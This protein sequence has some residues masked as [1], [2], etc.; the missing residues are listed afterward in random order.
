MFFSRRLDGMYSKQTTEKHGFPSG[1]LDDNMNKIQESN[2]VNEDQESDDKNTYVDEN[3]NLK[4]FIL[5]DE[6]DSES[7]DGSYSEHT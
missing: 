6:E 5:D 3:P 7:D 2:D 4:D 1:R